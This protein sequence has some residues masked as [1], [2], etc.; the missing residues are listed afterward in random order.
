MILRNFDP[1]TNDLYITHTAFGAALFA[2]PLL[3]GGN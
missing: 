1:E 2:V 3:F